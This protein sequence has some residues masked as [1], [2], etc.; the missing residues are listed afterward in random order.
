M[1]PINYPTSPVRLIKPNG[2][3][4]YKL[5]LTDAD[6]GTAVINALALATSGD[7]VEAGPGSYSFTAAITIPTGVSLVGLGRPVFTGTGF[8]DALIRIVNNNITVRN[9]SLISDYACIGAE[10][11][12]G[13]KTATGI[14]LRDL[15][16]RISDPNGSGLYWAG[17]GSNYHHIQADIWNCDFTTPVAGGGGSGFGIRMMLDA[18]SYVRVFN[19]VAFGDTDGGLFEGQTGAIVDIFGGVYTSTLD[20]LTCAGSCVLNAYYVKGRGGVGG[21]GGSNGDFYRDGG[22]FNVFCCDAPVS[23]GLVYLDK[24]NGTAATVAGL[25]LFSAASIS[26]QRTA[27]G[28]VNPSVSSNL[29]LHWKLDEVSGTSV[30]DA[31]GNARTGTASAANWVAG[32]FGNAYNS[33]GGADITRSGLIGSPTNVTVAG[34]GKLD[35]TG[36]G[37][38][39]FFELGTALTL[40]LQD[41][42]NTV[43]LI[44]ETSAGAWSTLSF[45]KTTIMGGWYHYA[46]VVDD[47][48]NGWAI[49]VNGLC[50]VSGTMSNSIYWGGGGNLV[51]GKQPSSSTYN[52]TGQIDDF[53]IYT[54]ALTSQQIRVL[55]GNPIISPY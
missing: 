35:A 38:A 52:F 51:L 22:T 47:T 23:S 14:E 10:G 37:G 18:T 28:V 49:Y 8:S 45:S 34:W 44:M 24:I 4:T 29:Y 16:G 50:V 39:D 33:T 13:V 31:S 26:A 42:G 30:A 27:I 54:V 6:R 25:A 12:G 48:N 9:L 41:G 1:F 11:S 19:T 43:S 46:I 3:V 36:G 32:V 55:A 15:I 7:T 53:R 40:R 17:G 20:G 2:Q 21:G 5:G